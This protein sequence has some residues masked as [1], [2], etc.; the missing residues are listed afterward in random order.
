MGRWVKSCSIVGLPMLLRSSAA[1]SHP[2]HHD[3]WGVLETQIKDDET[4]YFIIRK[5]QVMKPCLYQDRDIPF[6]QA[7]NINY[8]LKKQSHFQQY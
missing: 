5:E 7:L 8:I 4:G 3:G 6:T 1:A 2:P